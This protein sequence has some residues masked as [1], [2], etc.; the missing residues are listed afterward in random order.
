MPVGQRCTQT[1]TDTS[2]YIRRV[3]CHTYEATEVVGKGKRGEDGY[4]GTVPVKCNTDEH[5]T[6]ETK[7]NLDCNRPAHDTPV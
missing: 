7:C 5:P 1:P 2:P 6:D 3:A 4:I